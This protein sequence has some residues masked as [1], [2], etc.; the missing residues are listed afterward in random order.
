MRTIEETVPHSGTVSVSDTGTGINKE[1]RERIFD[2]FLPLKELRKEPLHRQHLYI[3]K[4]KAEGLIMPFIL[5]II[6]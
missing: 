4:R 2:P 6:W 1:T 3:H 5:R